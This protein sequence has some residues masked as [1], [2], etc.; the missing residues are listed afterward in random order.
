MITKTVRNLINENKNN[1]VAI[2]SDHAQT[3]IYSDLKQHIHNISGQLSFKGLTNKDRAAIV[4]PN[5]P[6][7]ATAFLAVSSYMS[8]APLNPSY[9][10]SEYEFYLNDLKPKIVIVEKNSSNPV[11]EAANKLNIEIC[12]IKK[13]DGA[14][15]GIFNLYDQQ[16][17]F[18]LPHEE[19]EA[20]V[21]HTSGTTSRPKVV[22]L[23]NK[24]IYSS[25][26][27]I[28]KTLK[29]TSND[30]CFNI[31]PL[32]H[33]HGLIAILSASIAAGAS[34]YASSGFNALKFLEKAKSENI[35]WYSGVPTMHQAILMRAKRNLIL[36]ENL[37]L[38]FVRSS[39]ASL[40]PAVFDLS[41]IHI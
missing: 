36:A 26:I 3:I 31:M 27:N 14:P 24:N 12:E 17:N 22:P 9:T 6:E 5:G 11:V 8:A 29:L 30:H 7:M 41:L 39:S 38:R 19:N 2:T 25:A 23:T 15:L 18:K 16:S 33:I 21:L 40:P 20:L 34:V 4:L 28:S 1:D 10:F 13:I 37:G 35:T 32:F